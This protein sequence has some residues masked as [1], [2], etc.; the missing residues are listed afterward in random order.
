MTKRSYSF[1]D[2][3]PID[4][5]REEART[6]PM[7]QRADAADS[8]LSAGI[9]PLLATEEEAAAQLTDRILEH[10]CSEGGRALS[11]KSATPFATLYNIFSDL[12]PKSSLLQIMPV[13]PATIS[14]AVAVCM[15]NLFFCIAGVLQTSSRLRHK[16]TILPKHEADGATIVLSIDKPA[17][18]DKEVEEAFGISATER[19]VLHR[20]ASV[21]SFSFHV[22]PGEQARVAFHLPLYSA[23]TFTLYSSS[24]LDS[25]RRAIALAAHYFA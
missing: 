14:P 1:Y 15:H 12:C 5:T 13:S 18:L 16:V 17:L 20:I 23:K 11:K 24:T 21:S 10:L 22:L 25:L 4:R 19:I 2:L 8:R 3:A 7:P 9:R 6:L